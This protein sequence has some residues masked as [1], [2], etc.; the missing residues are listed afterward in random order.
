ME[1]V[2]EASFART[3][4]EW[5]WGSVADETH[6]STISA[7][8]C[9]KALPLMNSACW[10]QLISKLLGILIIL[11]SCLN[12]IPVMVNLYTSKSAS[13]LSKSYLYGDFLIKANAALYGYLAAMPLTAYGENIAL[14]IQSVAVLLLAWHFAKVTSDEKVTVVVGAITYL[15]AMVKYL[16]EEYRY[17]L[18]ASIW[19]LLAYSRGAQIIE[20][21][22]VR[23]T[24]AQSIITTGTNLLGGLARI[25]TTMVEVGFDIPMLT[26]LFLSVGLNTIATIQY[27]V[28]KSNTEKLYAKAKD[29]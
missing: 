8:L 20:T 13:G 15:V 14:S 3:L 4:A 5:I 9:L 17:L 6:D 7:D 18:M 19:P 2:S 16:P 1:D 24:G 28:Y 25:G 21:Q 11:G 23:H 29:A 12:Q 22:K 10:S 26:G 27:F